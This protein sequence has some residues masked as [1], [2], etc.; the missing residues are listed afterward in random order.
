LVLTDDYDYSLPE[1]LI[2]Q[3]PLA[4]RDQ[5]RLVVYQQGKIREDHFRNLSLF[6][7][8]KSRLVFNDTRVVRARVLFS[9]PSGSLT[10]VFCL[11]P[12]GDTGKLE[13]ALQQPSPATWRCLIGKGKRWREKPLTKKVGKSG[14][15]IFLTAYR[16]S[17][18]GDGCH[19]VT[20]EWAPGEI[21]F[22]EVLEAAGAMPLPPYIDRPAMEE[23][24]TRYQTVFASNQGSVAAPTAGLHFTPD[25]MKELTGKQFSTERITLHVG[26]GTFRPVTVSEISG[27]VMHR[28]LFSV[29]R[30]VMDRLSRDETDPAIA[31][32][33]TSARTLESLYWLGSRLIHSGV[34]PE[35]ELGQWEPYHK[36]SDLPMP[37]AMEALLQWLTT[38]KKETL[39][40]STGLLIVPGYRFRVVKGL[41]TN[42]HQ[43]RSTLLMLVSAFIGPAWQEVYRYAI[44]RRFRFLS[45]GDACLFLNV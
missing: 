19:L 25:L 41:I 40:G 35:K 28:E 43:P 13:E 32:G 18:A 21:P 8:H 15:E 6:L 17:E 5:S 42:F 11:E 39:E 9:R 38:H 24:A 10:E 27:H 34:S 7:P 4:I 36:P 45:Y 12:A 23:D 3:H 33:T 37:E 29:K 26:L 16:G 31:V 2:A 22:G 1:E 30:E 14:Q 20:F 44:E